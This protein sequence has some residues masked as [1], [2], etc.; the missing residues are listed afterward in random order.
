[1]IYRFSRQFRSRK[2][3]ENHRHGS[4][5][6]GI[7]SHSV[8]PLILNGIIFALVVFVGLSYLLVINQTSV[9]GFEIK[10]LERANESLKRENRQLELQHADLH[11]L[12]AIEQAGKEMNL[13]ATGSIEYLPAVGGVVAVK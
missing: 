3:S 4:H 8:D 5:S 9:G 1:M 13:V 6:F 2:I 7:G 10:E 11:S 12:A